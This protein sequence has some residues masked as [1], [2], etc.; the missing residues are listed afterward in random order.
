MNLAVRP[1][2]LPDICQTR[3]RVSVHAKIW[4]KVIDKLKLTVRNESYGLYISFVTDGLV[5]APCEIEQIWWNDQGTNRMYLKDS[6]QLNT[7]VGLDT[8]SD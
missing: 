8:R 1:L 4:T 5:S 2:T 3:L 6:I 7:H